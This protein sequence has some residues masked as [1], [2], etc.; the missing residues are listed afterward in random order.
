[1]NDALN[2]EEYNEHHFYF[3]LRLPCFHWP[4]GSIT[5]P[6]TTLSLCFRIVFDYPCFIP[7]YNKVEQVWFSLRTLGNILANSEFRFFW[8]L[9]RI[10]ETI[11]A[12]NL[13][14]SK[15]SVWIFHTVSLPMES[16]SEIIPYSQ[17]TIYM[18]Q[19]LH[20]IDVAIS[21]ACHRPARSLIVLNSS[22]L[23]RNRLCHS[24]SRALDI[25]YSL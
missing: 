25:V 9:E 20:S 23:L 6:F 13:R 18:H 10:F 22:R 4:W 17:S 5:F 1:M 2:I 24:K 7:S 15:F 8:Y 12:N 19:L 3:P 11:F 16:C 14:I 21:P